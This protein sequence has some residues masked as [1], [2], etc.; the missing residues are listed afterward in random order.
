[1]IDRNEWA[2]IVAKIIR[3][4]GSIDVTCYGITMFPLLRE[5]NITTVV[6]VRE[7]D[8]HIGDVCLF[9]NAEGHMLMFRIIAIDNKQKPAAYIFRGDTCDQAEQPVPFSRIM[10]KLKVVHRDG[11]V[12]RVHHW[13][14]RL[15]EAA[16]LQ[17][18]YWS[19]FSR[20]AANRRY[21]RASVM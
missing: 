4:R 18:P 17:I 14:V 2:G 21:N 3:N 16:A 6:R 10:G 5:G 11:R 20:W 12:I 13:E 9:E 19:R 8:L 7:E 15:L 1:M